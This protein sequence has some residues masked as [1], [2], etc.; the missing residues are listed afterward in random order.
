MYFT[1]TLIISLTSTQLFIDDAIKR[2]TVKD[3]TVD[4]HSLLLYIQH[5]AARQ[6]RDRKE[7]SIP[8][9]LL[10]AVSLHH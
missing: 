6:K 2:K 7:N 4:E 10:G 8:G 5:S 1:Q 3:D 9:T